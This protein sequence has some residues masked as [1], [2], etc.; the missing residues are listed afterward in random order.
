MRILFIT[1]ANLS[2]NPRLYKEIVLAESLGH[3][4]SFI[5]FHQG[6]WSDE[7]DL[8]LVKKTQPHSYYLS[9]LR[10]P[11][12][13]WLISS[14]LNNLCIRI[15]PLFKHSLWITSIAH[16]KRTFPILKQLS[17]VHEH[18]DLVIGHNLGA[19]YP[20]W[21]FAK[22]ANIPFGFDVE[23]YYPGEASAKTNRHEVRRREVLMS[24]LLPKAIY[25]SCASPMIGLQTHKLLDS[26]NAIK[27][28]VI[29][30]CFSQ[31]DF[32]LPVPNRDKLR[33]VWFSQNI[34][35]GRGLEWT[36]PVLDQL[37][38]SI[39]LTLIGAVNSVFYEEYI[40]GRGYIE[41]VQP[42]EQKTLNL[43]LSGYDVG[44][45]LELN[46]AD[47][48]R[49]LCLTNKIWGYLQAGLFIL[50]TDT[51]AQ[52]EFI[53]EH[54][55]HGI[56]TS[57][58]KQSFMQAVEKIILD[59]DRIRLEA[60]ERYVKAQAFNWETESRKLEGMWRE[61]VENTVGR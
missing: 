19:L 56:L 40:K 6:G 41:I 49:Q 24:E 5:A 47:L 9:A 27:R 18:Y 53:T 60:K 50:A 16:N 33:M 8:T 54:P 37:G 30:N 1:T 57:Q 28:I 29:N 52:R 46:T 4:I 59:K 45:A 38:D 2:T 61:M 32:K 36:L 25:Y 48:N 34:N 12:W 44:L 17:R 55:M 22:R 13:P 3:R 7:T 14:F 21:S 10:T 15:W 31:A 43:S 42:L 35:Q 26:Y 23:D 58:D 11:F 51:P 39:T 20:S